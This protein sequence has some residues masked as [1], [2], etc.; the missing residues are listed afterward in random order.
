MA[1]LPEA[2]RASLWKAAEALDIEGVER[3]IEEVARDFEPLA[4]SLKG[5]LEEFHFDTVLEAL[6]EVDDRDR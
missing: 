6:A 2:L 1:S 3:A 5:L 4:R